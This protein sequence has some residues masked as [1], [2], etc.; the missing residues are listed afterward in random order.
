MDKKGIIFVVSAPSGAGKTSLCRGVA[1]I[2][3]NLQYSVSY[4]TRP[5]RPGEVHGKDY[6]FVDEATFRDKID[7][8][9]FVEWAE[10][11]GH[12]YGTSRELLMDWTDR[13]IDVI[14]DI[15]S[16]GAMTLKKRYSDGVYIYILPPSFEA[17]HQRLVN[18]KSDSPEEVARRLQKAREEIWNYRQYYYLIVN[19]DFKK[20]LKEL[21]AVIIAERIKMKQMNLSWIEETFIKQLSK[22]I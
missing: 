4:T 6:F 7:K 12:L 3:P 22:E 16:Q 19:V 2:V 11:H 20:A 13:G 8:N 5:P 21:E 17:L 1:E 18:R 9:D 14:L 10:V 15:D